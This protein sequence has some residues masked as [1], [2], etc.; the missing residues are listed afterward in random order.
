[1][2]SG[3]I[4]AGVDSERGRRERCGVEDAERGG[5]GDLAA[6]S[7][8]C[9]LPPGKG[10]MRGSST[11]R[12]AYSSAMRWREVGEAERRASRTEITRCS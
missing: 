12:A 6:R 9:I 5:G 3:E 8:R 2:S 10:T 4:S 11:T 1:M 7:G